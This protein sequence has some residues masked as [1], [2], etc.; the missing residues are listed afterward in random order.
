MAQTYKFGNG[1]WATKKGST[2]AYNDENNNFKPL[3]FD[4]TRSTGATRVNKQGLIEVVSNNE[5]RIDLSQEIV[6]MDIYF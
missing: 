3:P 4:F 6:Q 2:L 5:P 1:T